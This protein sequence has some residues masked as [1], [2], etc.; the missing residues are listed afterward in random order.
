MQV[1][2]NHF[3][4]IKNIVVI[5]GTRVNSQIVIQFL[6]FLHLCIFWLNGLHKSMGFS[7]QNDCPP[8]F[9]MDIAIDA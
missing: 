4:W 6:Y 3:S 8:S 7:E 2:I 5:I 9:E 1:L